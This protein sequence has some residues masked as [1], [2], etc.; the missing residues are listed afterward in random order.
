[1]ARR[2]RIAAHIVGSVPIDRVQA[3]FEEPIRHQIADPLSIS[4]LN[5][6]RYVAVI[7]HPRPALMQRS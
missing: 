5:D 2:L 4:V 3:F 1:V 6:Q 7:G